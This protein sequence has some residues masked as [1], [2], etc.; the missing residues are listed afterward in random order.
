MGELL[1]ASRW[2]IAAV[3]AAVL[4]AGCGT[5][6]EVTPAQASAGAP[7]GDDEGSVV[8]AVG[9]IADCGK[10]A[11]GEAQA[12]RTAELLKTTTGPILALGDIAYPKGSHTDF[13]TCFDPIWGELKPRILPVPGN[14]EYL[15]PGAGPYYAYFG[16]AAGEPGRGYYSTDIGTWH[17]VALNSNIGAAAG[18][19]QVQW[20]RVDLA[21]S[22]AKCTLAFW[23]HPVFTSSPRGNNAAMLDVWRVLYDAGVEVVLNG[24]E[25]SYERFAP[26]TP[27]GEPD[28]ARGIREFVVGT[29]GAT[30]G[31]F[32]AIDANSE[33]RERAALGVLRLRLKAD[34]YAWQFLSVAGYKFSDR[35]E[36]RCHN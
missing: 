23:H 2:L 15:T 8:Y 6:P 21:A 7:A 24:H 13:A 28:H 5:S 20:L 35:G 32:G 26:Q 14:H 25:H 19:A 29:G 34:G 31:F 3:A 36:G 1:F 10:R 11:P 27:R 17:I 4:L 12:A 18:S 9:D 16:A 33:S 22:R 30:A